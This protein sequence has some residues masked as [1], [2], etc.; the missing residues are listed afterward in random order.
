MDE[1]KIFNACL[2]CNYKNEKLTPVLNVLYNI[3][4]KYDFYFTFLT[5]ADHGNVVEY[6][7]QKKEFIRNLL[8]I[9]ERIVKDNKY[10]HLSQAIEFID[11]S[12]KL[13]FYYPEALELLYYPQEL[14]EKSPGDF[15]LR[16]NL[17]CEK[18]NKYSKECYPFPIVDYINCIR[19]HEYLVGRITRYESGSFFNQISYRIAAYSYLNNLPIETTIKMILYFS[20]NYHNFRDYYRLNYNTANQFKLECIIVDSI[21][22]SFYGYEKVIE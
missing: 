11:Q 2:E 10:E 13:H 9:M 8:L 3:I 4:E 6:R 20:D 15:Y 17:I 1:L 7:E 14:F 22:N 19:D 21:V 18:K 5:M 16:V 12:F